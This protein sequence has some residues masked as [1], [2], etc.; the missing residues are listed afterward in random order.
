MAQLP[1]QL[2]YKNDKALIIPKFE[3]IRGSDD[4]LMTLEH[5]RPTKNPKWRK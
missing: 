1:A 4:Y 5:T 3:T 2:G